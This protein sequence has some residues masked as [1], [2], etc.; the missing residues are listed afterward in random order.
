MYTYGISGRFKIPAVM[1]KNRSDCE[2]SHKQKRAQALALL[3][4]VCHTQYVA[5]HLNKTERWVRKWS[6]RR[7]VRQGLAD[8]SP[9]WTAVKSKG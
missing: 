5:K 8:Y 1:S 3:D 7:D 2:L 4:T 9:H 6:Q